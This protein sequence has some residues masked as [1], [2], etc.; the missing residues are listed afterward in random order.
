MSVCAQMDAV[1]M[2]LC[3]YRS[4]NVA[5]TLQPPYQFAALVDF[6]CSKFDGLLPGE[7][8][9]FYKIPGH[10]N[11]MLQNDVDMRNLVC[12]AH[13]F[14]LQ[15]IDVIHEQGWAEVSSP[16]VDEHLTSNMNVHNGMNSLNG[17]DMDDDLDLLPTFCLHTE[18]VFLSAPWANGFTHI[19]QHFEGGASEFRIMLRKYAVECGF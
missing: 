15:L 8:I 18:K 5:Y 2:L 19:G 14:C 13:A 16:I 11:F 9:L 7:I 17:M 10:N 1:M 6:V 4:T 3:C 12:L